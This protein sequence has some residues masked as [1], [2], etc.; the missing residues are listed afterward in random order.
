MR[1]TDNEPIG[2]SRSGALR[3]IDF[4]SGIGGF[5]LGLT[6]AGHKCVGFCEVD[7]NAVRSYKAMHLLTAHESA[8]LLKMET[9]DAVR[10]IDD[11]NPVGKGLWHADDIRTVLPEDIPDADL[12]VFGFPCQAFSSAGRR[13]GFSDTRGTLIFEILRLAQVRHPRYLFAENVP[14]LL[15]HDRGNTFATILSALAELGYH[16][17]WQVIDS[18]AYVPQHRERVYIIGRFGE[19][20]GRKIF[21]FKPGR[22][23]ASA[24]NGETAQIQISPEIDANSTASCIVQVNPRCPQSDR[25]Y[26][27]EGICPTLNTTNEPMIVLPCFSPGRKKTWQNGRRIKGNGENMFTLTTT[28]CHGIL[29]RAG[30][31]H[32]MR[33]RRLT[34]RECFRLQ[35]FPDDSFDRARLVNSDTQLYRQAGNSVT[36]PV[37]TDIGKRLYE[38]ERDIAI[39]NISKS[40]KNE[41]R[42]ENHDG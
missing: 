22:A 13:R 15:T 20:A 29:I 9:N 16:A 19:R 30:A 28:D 10:Y 40:Q 39:R 18:A 12:Y 27:A 21:P 7:K 31:D 25:V 3:F 14:G 33:I 34:P 5:H 41:S 6:E 23:E 4:F 37:I 24:R 26:A 1:E 32:P 36:V 35:G 42:R 2:K 38:A 8:E 17:E 11:V